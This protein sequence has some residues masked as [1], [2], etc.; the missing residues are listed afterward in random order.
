VAAGYLLGIVE[1][2][3]IG[4]VSS[5]FSD[6]IVFTLLIVVLIWKPQGLFGTTW[7]REV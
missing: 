7:S 3:T 6:P 5:Q 1:A 4:L 2:Y